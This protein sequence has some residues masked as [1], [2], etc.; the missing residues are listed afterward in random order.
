M[1]SLEGAESAVA[2]ASGTRRVELGADLV[3]HSATKYLGGQGDVIAGIVA[4]S[5]ELTD[6]VR[7][8]GLKDMT[9]ATRI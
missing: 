1:A 4:E 2:L 6:E 8:Y 9:G 3:V 5:Q 7:G